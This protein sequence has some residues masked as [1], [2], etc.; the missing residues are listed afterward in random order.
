[1]L[2]EKRVGKYYRVPQEDF[3]ARCKESQK[4]PIDFSGFVYVDQKTKYKLFCTKHQHSYGQTGQSLFEGSIGCKHCLTEYKS[5]QVQENLEIFISKFSSKFPDKNYDFSKSIYIKSSVHMQV[6]CDRGHTFS[7]RPNNLL[8]GYGC[9]ECHAEDKG[10]VHSRGVEASIAK[11]R[12]VHGDTYDYSLVTEIKGSKSKIDILCKTHGKFTTTPDTHGQG[13]GCPLCGGQGF[14]AQNPA[15]F[16]ILKVTE[17]VI[18]FGISNDVDRRLREINDKSCFDIE[19]MYKFYFENGYDARYI[20][21]EVYR[22][23]T[24][25]RNVVSKADLPSGYVET[26]Y[27]SNLP[28]LLSIVENYKPA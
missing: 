7:I 20:E 12:E 26:T 28:K 2:K 22:D 24:I 18:K 13:R 6:T 14:K 11:F 3:I 23:S 9:R 1:M 25:K 19:L 8:T 16:Y 4:V 27:M 10:H 5:A 17:N 21:T 15:Y